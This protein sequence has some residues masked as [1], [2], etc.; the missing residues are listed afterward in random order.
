MKR[1]YEIEKNVF[2]LLKEES[3][4][5]IKLSVFLRLY[6]KKH[7]N[8][9]ISR[10]RLEQV[11]KQLE[12][13][14]NAKIFFKEKGFKL[15]LKEIKKKDINRIE[16]RKKRKITSYQLAYDLINQLGG[17]I[18]S[19]VVFEK[20]KRA[21]SDEFVIKETGIFQLES[22]YQQIQILKEKKLIEIFVE[23]ILENEIINIEYEF[24]EKQ[25]VVPLQIKEY[26]SR[27]FLITLNPI[28]NKVKHFAFD[29]ITKAKKTYKTSEIQKSQAKRILNSYFKNRIGV[30]EGTKTEFG[31]EFDTNK[32]Y[33]IS[34]DVER[35]YFNR[36][37]KNKMWFTEFD[38]SEEDAEAIGHVEVS[39]KSK[40][41]KELVSKIFSYK[42]QVKVK[43]PLFLSAH[44]QEH[45]KTLLK[46]YID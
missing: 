18:N 42:S 44:I 46:N 28:N 21:I 25:S 16:S 14:Y 43:K 8:S 10:Y 34:F 5:G 3:L 2:E 13:V 7:S 19:S 1:N 33:N 22:S 38:S 15:S 41:N 37:F 35:N 31:E 36:Y 17:N 4:N 20:I 11:I 9:V 29:R 26:N 12:N 23:V 30:S 32:T 24:G 40:I 39:V 45:L 27:W 6:N